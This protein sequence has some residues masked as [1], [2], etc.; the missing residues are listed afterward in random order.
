MHILVTGAAGFIGSHTVL[1]L[2]EANKGYTVFCVDNCSNAVADSN[3]NAICLNRVSQ[4]VNKPIPFKNLDLCDGSALEP[5]FK[6]QKF[7][8]V[9]HLSALKSVAESIAEPLEYYSNNILG[10]LNLVK[11]CLKYNVTNFVFSSS[12]TVYGPP[13][14]LPITEKSQTGKGITNPYGQTKYMSEQ[15][16]MDVAKANPNWNLIIL[17]YF[18]PVGAHKSGLIGEDPKGT[19]NNLMPYVSQVAVGK[20]EVLTIH[21][22][23]FDTIDGTGVRDFIHVVDLAKGHV[24]ALERFKNPIETEI[25]NLGTGVGYSVKQMVEAFEKVTGRKIPTKIGE[26]R[27]GDVASVFCDPK[28][29]EEQLGWK[30]ELGLEDMCRDLWNWQTKNPKG[31]M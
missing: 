28:L 11:M 30:A 24:Q 23:T 9:I 6:E 19:P 14:E 20:L 27:K 31:F 1:E 7:D 10:C 29:A 25:Y 18:N 4:I 26:A 21:G 22:D 8:A 17:R 15:I 3:G 12:A 16:M 5:I 2:I 13:E